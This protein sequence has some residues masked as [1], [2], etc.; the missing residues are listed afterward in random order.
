MSFF[1]T[2]VPAESICNETARVSTPA[3]GA[4][5]KVRSR[6]HA[7]TKSSP[8]RIYLIAGMCVAILQCHSVVASGDV[9]EENYWDGLRSTQQTDVNK[10]RA[11]HEKKIEQSRTKRNAKVFHEKFE[12][13]QKKERLQALGQ[14]KTVRRSSVR[15]TRPSARASRSKSRSPKRTSRSKTPEAIR[16]KRSATRHAI[17]ADRR[18]E[19][20]ERRAS[21]C[22]T[23]QP[24]ASVRE[25]GLH[26]FNLNALKID[27]K[28]LACRL[29]KG[30][31]KYHGIDCLRCWGSCTVANRFQMDVFVKGVNA[32][33]SVKCSSS[34]LTLTR[35]ITKIGSAKDRRKVEWILKHKTEGIIRR[36]SRIVYR[37][38][39]EVLSTKIKN[40]FPSGLSR[41]N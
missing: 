12:R 1:E 10:A 2:E 34:G 25:G 30:E 4:N 36:E 3:H 41:A 9:T 8:M 16:R 27:L 33:T 17:T 22:T 38:K 19:R 29:C 35:T 26:K 23:P 20:E 14:Y 39:K 13:Q 6:P 5:K 11:E 37:K 31:G 40:F 24:V 15:P 18:K 28:I 32:S 7:Q 21:T